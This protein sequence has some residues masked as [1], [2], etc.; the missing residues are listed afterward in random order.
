MPWPVSSRRTLNPRASAM[1]STAAPTSRS[2]APAV[3]AAMPRVRAARVAAI[4]RSSAP[5]TGSTAT[6]VAV[7]PK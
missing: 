4:R 3:A 2:R 1:R 6:V 5:A 7:S